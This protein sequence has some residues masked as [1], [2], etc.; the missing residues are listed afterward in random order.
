M[1]ERRTLAPEEGGVGRGN[2]ILIVG[3]DGGVGQENV[4]NEDR[5]KIYGEQRRYLVLLLHGCQQTGNAVQ[6]VLT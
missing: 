3:E 4:G 1:S 5:H 6:M 2:R